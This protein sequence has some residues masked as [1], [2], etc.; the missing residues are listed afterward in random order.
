MSNSFWDKIRILVTNRCN[1][2]CSFCHNEGQEKDSCKNIMSFND[3]KVFVDF[4]KELPLSEINISGGEPFLNKEVSEMLLYLCENF[5]S[6]ITCATNLS[7]ITDEDIDKL[8]GTRVKF[9][10]QFPYVSN[11]LFHKSTGNG[12]LSYILEK[13][14]KI[15]NNN[16]VVGL[17]TVVQSNN[18]D[19]YERVILFAIENEL[20]LKL[21]PQ[22]GNNSESKYYRDSLY[23]LLEKYSIDF[24]ERYINKFRNINDYSFWNIFITW[25]F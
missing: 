18:T 10:V 21:L 20:P 13:I 7:L 17:N 5:K 12:N 8:S 19:V 3:F 1:Y 4:L 14:R 9:N 11:E 6:D 25:T 23:P 15:R 24:I 16:L 22:I 2:T